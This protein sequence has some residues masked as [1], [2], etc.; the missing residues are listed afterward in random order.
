MKQDEFL[1]NLLR[2]MRDDPQCLYSVVTALIRENV[3]IPSQN[4]E[5]K[6]KNGTEDLCQDTSKRCGTCF[7]ITA[8]HSAPAHT[9][10]SISPTVFSGK[11]AARASR[12]R[13]WRAR[14]RR[15]LR[16]FRS[17][18]RL[19]VARLTGLSSTRPPRTTTAPASIV[20]SSEGAS[21]E[22]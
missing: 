1:K 2:E 21:G 12:R 8:G 3:R 11:M 9:S 22:R 6:P 13:T 20:S 7:W 5:R 14:G 18:A 10:S 16:S 19:S 15:A 17:S 4:C